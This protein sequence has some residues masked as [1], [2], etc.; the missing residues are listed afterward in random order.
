MAF[1]ITQL[2]EGSVGW[3]STVNANFNTIQTALRLVDSGQTTISPATNAT[4]SGSP[5]TRNSNEVFTID[6][7]LTDAV[8]GAR[9]CQT[10]GVGQQIDLVNYYG[11]LT[12][13]ANQFN[14]MAGNQNGSGSGASR[15]L[16]W[17]VIGNSTT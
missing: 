7:W 16:V 4:L 12:G 3:A 2:A 15:T 14:A 9:F 6:G 10:A 8:S 13:S 5:E 1:T 11:S 17:K